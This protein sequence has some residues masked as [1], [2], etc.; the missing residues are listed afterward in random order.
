[1]ML[2]NVNIALSVVL[3]GCLLSGCNNSTTSA[4]SSVSSPSTSDYESS[5][6][7]M[8]NLDSYEDEEPMSVV[9]SST[10]PPTEEPN[11][12]DSSE[13]S[14]SPAQPE[15]EYTDLS[16]LSEE[17]QTIYLRAEDFCFTLFGNPGNLLYLD[18]APE[19]RATTL[20]YL[21]SV[22]DYELYDITFEAFENLVHSI[23]TTAYT[24]AYDASFGLYGEGA[25][26]MDKWGY[27]VVTDGS[28]S[29]PF[30]ED[31]Y[32]LYNVSFDEFSER[33]HSIFTD[34][35]LT[36]TDYAIKFKNYN[37]RV[38]VH[39]SL[40]NEMVAGMTIY[41]QEQYPDTYR[42]VKNT[43]EKVE[44]TLISHYD[45]DGSVENPL[46]VYIIEYPI[47][48]VKTDYGWRIDDF[49]TSRYG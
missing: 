42:L 6:A 30:I 9:P 39:F 29:V 47:R 32:T 5:S 49:H 46:E 1:M 23:F 21:G 31:H 40:H 33:I 43:P 3:C 24:N 27:K 22:E 8:S 10:L 14:A 26:L 11:T 4:S 20:Q 36:S 17:Q 19:F 2:Q 13:P 45:R 44:F 12:P 35:C 16:F 38:A 15:Q 28:D 7:A 41:V 34:N 37:G 25:N 18:W 48:M